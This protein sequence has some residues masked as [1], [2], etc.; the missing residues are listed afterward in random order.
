MKNATEALQDVL[1][2]ARE[3]AETANKNGLF[4]TKRL[5]I[6]GAV[7]LTVAGAVIVIKKVRAARAEEA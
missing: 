7:A 3:V 2:D 1:E 6:A 5:V 4:T